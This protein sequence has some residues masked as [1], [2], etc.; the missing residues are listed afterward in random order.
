MNSAAPWGTYVC[1][2]SNNLVPVVNIS[3]HHFS[4]VPVINKIKSHSVNILKI[5]K[6]PSKYIFNGQGWHYACFG[7]QGNI[8][9]NVYSRAQQESGWMATGTQKPSGGEKKVP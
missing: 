7:N 9:S 4:L 2:G 3:S 1:T 5:L 6:I 8:Y